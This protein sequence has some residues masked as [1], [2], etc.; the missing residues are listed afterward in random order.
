[1]TSASHTLLVGAVLLLLG[2]ATDGRTQ[3]LPPQ[4]RAESVPRLLATG[5]LSDI[6]E[7]WL[8]EQSQAFMIAIYESRLS[9]AAAIVDE[10]LQRAPEDPRSHLLHARYLRDFL[11]DQNTHRKTI[12]SQMIPVFAAADR[13]REKA[14]QLLATDQDD[15][16]G[17]LYRGWARMFEAQLH[18]VSASY[19]SAGRTSKRAKTDLDFVLERDPDNAQ[20]KMLMGAFYYFADGLPSVVKFAA[21]VL[22]LPK[23]DRDL[24]LEYV[25]D[26]YQSGAFGYQDAFAIHGLIYFAF[27]ADFIKALP[28]FESLAEQFPG[29]ARLVEPFAVIDLFWP[30]RLDQDRRRI[31]RCYELSQSAPDSV[32]RAGGKRLRYYQLLGWQLTGRAAEAGPA[33]E[34][35][36]QNIPSQPDWLEPSVRLALADLAL[37]G[38]DLERAREVL[39]PLQKDSRPEKWMRYVF[40]NDN[41]AATESGVVAYEKLQSAARALY[42]GELSRASE[43]LQAQS[44]QS[45]PPW[46]FYSAELAFLRGD[47]K[48]AREGFEALRKTKNRDRFYF[49]RYLS[50]LRLG[51]IAAREG[52]NDKA[53]EYY[54]QA[55]NEH[56]MKD[57]LRHVANSRRRLFSNH[58]EAMATAFDLDVLPPG[59]R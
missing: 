14:E 27:E 19:W 57:L 30:Q 49:F 54:E 36:L 39:A 31:A 20:A 24:G 58:D 48:T 50:R 8:E 53:K 34:E 43:I 33:M 11:S 46:R 5:L 28:T 3:S 18:T 56:E 22:R 6:D 45:F 25:R 13:A 16:A 52:D 15:L 59:K 1:M 35:L 26:A 41:I 51:E 17:R 55:M 12:E 9:D 21:W 2:V 10:V 40:E 4:L 7:R 37:L 38:G 44:D 32:T 42:A 23:G 47:T 29:N